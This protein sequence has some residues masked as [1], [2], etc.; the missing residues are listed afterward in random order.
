MTSFT[1]NFDITILKNLNAILRITTSVLNI[2][3]RKLLFVLLALIFINNVYGKSIHVIVPLCDNKYQGIVKV[4]ASL[5]NGES[6]RTNLYWGAL[7][8]VKTYLKKSSNWTLIKTLKPDSKFIA[9]RCVFKNNISDDYLIADAYWGKYIYQAN[10]DFI[11]FAYGKKKGYVEHKEKKIGIASN[12]NLLIYAGHNGLMDFKLK[13][14]TKEK[15]K[16]PVPTIVLACKSKQYYLPLFDKLGIPV[17]LLTKS[18]MA[19]EA[20]TI[21]AISNYWLSGKRSGI[22][23]SAAQAYSKYQKCSLRAAKTVFWERL[24]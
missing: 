1:K 15:S 14:T 8:G 22:S 4:S 11:N 21:D 2:Q 9:E 23:L 7:Y 5:G 17:V 18:F 12:S 13:I 10:L 3:K 19:P 16:N 24:K 6:T 20:Y